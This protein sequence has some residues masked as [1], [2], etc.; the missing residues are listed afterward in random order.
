MSELLCILLVIPLAAAV[1]VALLGPQRTPEIRWVSLAASLA[2]AVIALVLAVNLAVERVAQPG[3][4]P[5]KSPTLLTFEP[6]YVTILDVL[7]VG[8]GVIQFYIGLDGLNVWLVV[9]TSVLMVSSVLVS[10]NSPQVRERLNEYF[11]WLLLLE[12]GMIVLFL[13]F[14]IVLFYVFFELTLVPLFFLIGIWGGP[15]RRHAARKFFIYTLAGSLITLV[16]LIAAVLL[17][18]QSNTE[19]LSFS[20]PKLI[21]TL[22][23]EHFNSPNQRLYWADVQM[24][25]FLALIAGFSIKVPLV[26][27]HTWLPLAHVEAPTAGSVLLAGILLKIGAY[28]FLR[29][30]LP[31]TPDASLSLGVPLIGTLAVIGIIYGALCALAQ[32]M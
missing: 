4:S 30:C 22:N 6:S 2:A 3:E 31:L 10:W 12:V 26:P 5:L 13:S 15:E 14:D 25:L 11:A 7:P 9:L 1:I 27:L 21:R 16:G 28:G 18:Y 23:N 24:W 8:P 32:A 29:L 20:I 17:V 19:E